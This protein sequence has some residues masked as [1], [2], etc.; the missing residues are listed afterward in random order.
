MSILWSAPR[1]VGNVAERWQRSYAETWWREKKPAPD[2]YEL[3]L[4]M[5]RVLP[6]VAVALEDSTNGVLAAK[7]AGLYTVF[8]PSQWTLEQTPL[9]ADLVLN[10][11]GDPGDPVN[12]ASSVRIR[13]AYLELA[14][15][16]RLR[17]RKASA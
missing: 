4:S 2:I 14:N 7:A 17:S 6:G 13:A 16:D 8:I 15:L 1:L 3:L 11:L 10:S 5:L 12:S 9:A